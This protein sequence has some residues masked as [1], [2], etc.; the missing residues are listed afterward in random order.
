MRIAAIDIGTNSIHMV[1][2]KAIGPASFEVVDREREVVQ[3]GRGSFSDGRLRAA[4]IRRTI[5]AL[6]RFVALARRHQVDRIVC[7][8]T[9]AVREARNGGAFLDAAR[10]AAGVLPR[11][12]PAAEE[13]RLIWLGVKS[14]LQLD[15]APALI[16]DIGGGSM[17]LVVGD[18]DRLQRVI[19]VALGA[20]RLTE[21]MLDSDPPSRRDLQR[22]RRHIRRET[23][24]A[25]ETVAGAEPQ[26]FYGSSGSIHAL[27]Q[28][29]HWADTGQPLTQ[30]NGHRMTIESLDRLTR[31]LQRMNLE[32]R[33]RLPGIDTPRAEIILPGALV[34]LHV[35]E[36]LGAPGITISDFGVRE[37]LVTDYLL[38]HA[39]EVS[40]LELIDDL[41]LRS[42]MALLTKFFPESRHSQHVARLALQLFDGLRFAHRLGP[43]ERELL[44]YA[45]LLHDIGAVIGYDGHG[46]H[47]YYI[48]RNGNLRGFS[49]ADVAIV[50]T[51][52]RYH[53]KSRPR[54]HDEGF[55]ELT[56]DQRRIVRWLAAILRIAEGLDRSHYQL[57]PAV[58]VVRR[59]GR[60]T[61]QA[62]TLRDARLELWAARRRTQMLEQLLGVRVRIAAERA[63]E[64]R[65]PQ[66]KPRPRRARAEESTPAAG[67]HAG[68]VSL[69]P[70]A[71]GA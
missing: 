56:K 40:A 50:A 24:D 28:A 57:V 71:K 54:K 8:A 46:E 33:E 67:P 59:D 52:A 26:A 30:L 55:A 65:A 69:R 11:V 22:L 25:L 23:R 29:A 37:G 51:V 13:G 6:H 18:R 63:G 21:T 70:R 41:R 4:A 44:S 68:V 20:L 58:R 19:S 14:A 16:L 66:H 60:V 48:I 64:S 36:Q 45:S 53:G 9:A 3:I 47:S 43:E 38:S 2:A 5:D 39:R 31:R 27:A 10:A 49:A 62:S 12:I 15:A 42:V 34:L 1:I 32:E 17:Q 35:L 7:T 61:I